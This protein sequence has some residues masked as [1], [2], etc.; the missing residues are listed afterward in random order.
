MSQRK[1]ST[2]TYHGA[3]D[4]QNYAKELQRTFKLTWSA[5]LARAKTSMGV[6]PMAVTIG[7]TPTLL[8][9][10][11]TSEVVLNGATAASYAWDFGDGQSATTEDATNVYAG[12]GTYLVWLSVTDTNGFVSTAKLSVT[13]AAA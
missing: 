12:A 10:D 5:A 7:Y 9:V 4:V 3:G 8:S 13:V 6:S 11:F 1:G 2:R